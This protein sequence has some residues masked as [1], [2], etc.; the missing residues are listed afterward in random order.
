MIFPDIKNI[1]YSY[2]DGGKWCRRKQSRINGWKKG[3]QNKCCK[4]IDCVR[5]KTA[6]VDGG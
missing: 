6:S 3:E 5:R 2:M 1:R 4:P